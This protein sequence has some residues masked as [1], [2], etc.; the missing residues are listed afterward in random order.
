MI[1]SEVG[2]RQSIEI[3]ADMY[4]ALA[5]LHRRV[6]PQNFANYQ[7]LSEG[8]VEEIR[9]VQHDID[10]YLGVEIAESSETRS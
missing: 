5:E 3:L 9:R 2:L 7:L 8:P 1:Q 6:A 10:E 4:Q